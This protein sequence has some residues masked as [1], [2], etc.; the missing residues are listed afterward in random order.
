MK[1]PYR[2]EKLEMIPFQL[3]PINNNTYLIA[4]TELKEC[5]VIDPSFDFEIELERI[6][7]EGW[8]LKAIWLTHAHFD[9]IA[10]VAP[11][12]K[13]RKDIALAMHP[14]DEIIRAKG[15]TANPATSGNSVPIPKPTIDLKDQ[16]KIYLGSYAF[17]VLHTPGHAPGHCCF[18]QPEAGW[19]FTGDLIFFHDYGRTDLIG[20]DPQALMR[21]I[22]EKILVLP[23][24]TLIFPGH[25]DFTSVGN[26]K[27]FYNMGNS[28]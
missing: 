16:M 5:I 24:E 28:D 18:Y 14:A 11:A 12:M 25:D 15:G 20:S 26:E 22:R 10:G 1:Y 27:S 17:T 13:S 2:F 19:L 3:G 9:H 4:E 8:T 23:D 21:S 6:S 7:M